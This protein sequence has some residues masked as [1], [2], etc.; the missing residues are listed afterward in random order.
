M[1]TNFNTISDYYERV[2]IQLPLRMENF[3]CYSFDELSNDITPNI[4]AY[5]NDFYEIN[6][7]VG[8]GC[9]YKIDEFK[10]DGP[11]G[12][13]SIISPKRIQSVEVTPGMTENARGFSIFFDESFLANASLLHN[14][15]PF[16]KSTHSPGIQLRPKRVK[17]LKNIFDLI[18]YEYREYGS[19]ASGVLK[20]MVLATLNKALKDYDPNIMDDHRVSSEYFIANKF[21][22]LVQARFKQLTTVKEYAAELNVSA[23]YLSHCIKKTRGINALRLINTIRISHAKSLL[24]H[25]D[26]TSS[27]IAFDLNFPGPAHFYT[28]FKQIE[29]RTPKE[30][31]MENLK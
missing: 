25:T 20:N 15:F 9:S 8:P 5:R 18:L 27:Q 16:F 24:A 31:R 4:C 26:M 19:S 30:Y 6:F 7:D 10:F 21:E 14:D 13:L 12:H 17:E 28:L 3:S 29:H 2:N 1:I 22:S 23:K 11:K